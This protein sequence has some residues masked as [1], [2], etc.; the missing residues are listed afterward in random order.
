MGA[1]LSLRGSGSVS[2][3]RRFGMGSRTVSLSTV[4]PPR[5]VLGLLISP[6]SEVSVIGIIREG[7]KA[8]DG[9]KAPGDSMMLEWGTKSLESSSLS[10]EPPLRGVP[11]C[12]CTT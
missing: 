5:D 12:V 2:R 6:R 1:A 4:G 8:L 3:A 10:L 11:Y 9:S 7:V